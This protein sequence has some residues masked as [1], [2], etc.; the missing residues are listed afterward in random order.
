MAA[1]EA[2]K[3]VCNEAIGQKALQ[4]ADSTS[5]LEKGQRY[6]DDEHVPL[7]MVARIWQQQHHNQWSWE[8]KRMRLIC[9]FSLHFYVDKPLSTSH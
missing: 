5:Q 4:F 1:L 7:S 9:D 2:R 6:A 8:R 3:L